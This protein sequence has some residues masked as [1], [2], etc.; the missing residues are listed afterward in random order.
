MKRLALALLA[1]GCALGN[2]R[3]AGRRSSADESKARLDQAE[4]AARKDPPLL[5]R[6]GWL[7]YLILSDARGAEP[8]L[9]E[10]AKTG[11]DAQR[12][13]ALDGLGEIAEDRTD[14]LEA[15]RDFIAA[16]QSAPRDPAA[17]LAAVRLLDLEGEAPPVDDA[18]LEAAADLAAPAAPRAAR[19]VREAAARISGRRAQASGDAQSEVE[20]WRRMGAVQ[21]WRVGGPFAAL[22]L[23]DLGLDR[24]RGGA[25]GAARRR[26]G[27]LARPLSAREPPGAD[28]GGAARS[29]QA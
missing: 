15:A 2:H 14:S 5:A 4:A 25:G 21:H 20:A 16:L 1:A 7:R 22:R 26:G 27:H 6:A 13:L 28:G 24:G 29:G 8:E 17:E 12:A 19:L 11:P 10:A 23:F 9:A 3:D 18:I